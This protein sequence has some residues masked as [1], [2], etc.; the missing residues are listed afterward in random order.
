MNSSIVQGFNFHVESEEDLK[1][2]IRVKSIGYG[3]GMVRNINF[4]LGLILLEMIVAAV[5][6]AVG[7]VVSSFAGTSSQVTGLMLKKYL[8]VLVLFN[9]FNISY[10]AGLQFMYGDSSN[11]FYKLNIATVIASLVLPIIMIVLILATDKTHFGEFSETLRK[12]MSS[13][14]FFVID[15]LYR[16]LLGFLM[17]AQNE[18]EE[19]TIINVFICILFTLYSA[20]N[21]PFIKAYSNYRTALVHAGEL[22]VLSVAMY[23]RS[24]KSNTPFEE[25]SK[26]LAPAYLELAVIFLSAV[27]MG[28]ELYLKI[29]ELISRLSKTPK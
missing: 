3:S 7:K 14:L 15:I 17:S 29:K 24:M 9:T 16:L 27:C 19:A 4:M 28:Y 22:T 23:Y 18:V 6:F 21:K 25:K 8:L 20:S 10:S 2:P 26:I 1:V 11:Q 5:V 12:D 13:Q